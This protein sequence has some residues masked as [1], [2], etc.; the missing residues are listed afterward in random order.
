MIIAF[1]FFIYADVHFLFKLLPIFAKNISDANICFSEFGNSINMIK[2]ILILFMC[3]FI[4]SLCYCQEDAERLR[5][6]MKA[7]H[8]QFGFKID[9]CTQNA[10]DNTDLDAETIVRKSLEIASSIC[11]FTNDNITVEKLGE[12]E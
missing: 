1:P 3:F 12:A 10:Y 4:H 2:K 5:K 6:D 9:S 7:I 11:V 8:K